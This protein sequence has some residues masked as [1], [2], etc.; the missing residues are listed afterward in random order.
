MALD[1]NMPS[2]LVRFCNLYKLFCF[3]KQIVCIDFQVYFLPA[4]K[5]IFNSRMH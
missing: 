4:V 2:A 5:H 3:Y 1:G